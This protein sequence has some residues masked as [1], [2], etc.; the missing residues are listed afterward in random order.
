MASESEAHVQAVAD[1]WKKPVEI[2][3]LKA[4]WVLARWGFGIALGH[5]NVLGTNTQVLHAAH[6]LQ[7]PDWCPSTV[8]HSDP[9]QPLQTLLAYR[10]FSDQVAVES[11]KLGIA[12]RPFDPIRGGRW[13]SAERSSSLDA[14]AA[15]QAL[16]KVASR[17][18]IAISDALRAIQ[19][20]PFE[21]SSW[22]E[23][24]DDLGTVLMIEIRELRW[25]G[26]F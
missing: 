8:R 21:W 5:L 1:R 25:H 2:E 24:T 23:D 7:L 19:R 15:D 26:H 16:V 17:R 10:W 18:G 11:L 14:E 20:A 22:K 12:P 4:I 6:L 3:E 9:D 13:D